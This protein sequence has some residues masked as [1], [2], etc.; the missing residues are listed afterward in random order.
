MFS[1]GGKNARIFFDQKGNINEKRYSVIYSQIT[2][3][4]LSLCGLF[5]P[6]LR[7]KC[8]QYASIA[9]LFSLR[10]Q[11]NPRKL[12]NVIGVVLTITPNAGVIHRYANFK[13]FFSFTEKRAADK[14]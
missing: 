12:H 3:K 2:P 5:L 11:K 7:Q 10:E 1:L 13:P 4:I 14:R 9:P 8:S 6:S